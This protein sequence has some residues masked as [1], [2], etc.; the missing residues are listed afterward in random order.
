MGANTL[1]GLMPTA[2]RALQVVSRE[3]VGFIPAVSLDAADSR[4]AIGQQ[5]LVPLTRSASTVPISPAVTSPDDGDQTVDNVP[6]AITRSEAVPIR[7][8]GEQQLGMRNSGMYDPVLQRQFEQ[9]FRALTNY[10]EADCFAAAYKNASR[11]YGTAG[12]AP[13]AT[14]A[15]LLD[16]ANVRKILDDNGAPQSDLHLVLGSAAVVNLRGK[17]TILTKANEK[18]S[19][20]FRRTGAIADVPLAGF[21]LHNSAAVG[22]VTPG[23]GTSYVTNGSTAAKVNQVVLKTGT[24]TVLAG[25]V[26]TFDSDTSNRYVVN[27]GISAPGTITIGQ[28]GLRSA[29]ADA[30]TLTIGTAY[31]PN[32]AFDRNAI[33]LVTR[34]PAR[35]TDS[36]G[37]SLDAA[38]DSELLT[39]PVS[40]ITFEVSVY[41]QYRQVR[42]E[43]A[44]AWG[45]AAVQSQH[46]ATLLG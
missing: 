29:V 3:L 7:W 21:T 44:L 20:D 38:I 36:G 32:V 18:G 34:P 10:V 12:T 1:T 30:K 17:Q 6:I 13:F 33:Q 9:A 26:V 46:I 39:D 35:P 42:Y 11:A 40:G 19:D 43:V 25:D 2:Y 41:P 15:D 27:V 5:V 16:V 23:T 14:A 4:I 31:T 28:P 22:P 24:G 37:R 45:V 8:N